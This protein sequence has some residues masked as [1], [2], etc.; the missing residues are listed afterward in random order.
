YDL[1]HE[2]LPDTIDGV[3]G[4]T[5]PGQDGGFGVWDVDGHSHGTHVAGTIGAIG[6]NNIGVVGVNPDPTKF[7]FHISKGLS[8]N[9]SGSYA[10][11]IDCI[12][13]CVAKGAKVI[14]MSL[15]GSGSSS[16]MESACEAA[17]DDGVL[18]I[19]AAGNSGSTD[20]LYPASYPV[21]M[22]VASVAYGGGPESDTY[23]EL[24]YFSTRNDQ[25]EIAGPGS[26]V[27]ST[28]PNDG[29]GTKSGTSM[30]TPHVSG[31]AAWLISLFPNCNA[32][33]IR[34]AMLNS[35]REPPRDADGWDKLYGHGIVD[36]G[37]AY[38][39]LSS[40]GCVGAGGL[41]PSDAGEAPR[42][43][44]QGGTY[45]KDIGCTADHHCYIGA[46]FGP[47]FCNIDLSPNRCAPGTAPPPSPTASPH[48]LD[49]APMTAHNAVS[50]VETSLSADAV[51]LHGNSEPS[52]VAQP[53]EL[54]PPLVPTT[55][56]CDC[57]TN[58]VTEKP[59]NIPTKNPTPPPTSPPTSQCLQRNQKCGRDIPGTCCNGTCRGKDGGS[60][61]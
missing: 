9:G 42:E 46:S 54:K 27:Y 23:G 44:G 38:S 32:N 28:V 16:L 7:K 47:R 40:A 52:K 43:M 3:T 13:D 50:L 2:D 61:N 30:A 10:G 41:S 19:A 35:V 14:S 57:L 45:Q 25:V 6:S 31:V 56:V 37:A 39:L 29:Y 33:Q 26:S 18:V 60:C 49:T 5:P 24:S 17:Y 12:E 20:Y 11:I 53:K 21:V 51:V 1:G 22:S 4:F 58:S 55:F 15:G 36:A 34:N 59:T 8:D 48:S